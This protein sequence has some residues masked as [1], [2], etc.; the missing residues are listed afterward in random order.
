VCLD[1]ATTCTTCPA[2]GPTCKTA[3]TVDGTQANNLCGAPQQDYVNFI[4][5]ACQGNC[6]TVCANDFCVGMNPGMAC[7]D[8]LVGP[9]DAAANCIAEFNTCI[10]N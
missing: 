6:K 5:C 1:I 9:T 10:A 4:L 8:C 3:L 2:G 7:N